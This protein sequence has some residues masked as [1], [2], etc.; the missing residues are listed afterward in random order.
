[1]DI[2]DKTSLKVTVAHWLT[3]KGKSISGNGIEPDV[4]VARTAEDVA[5]DKDPQMEKAATLLIGI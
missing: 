3:P 5:A 1:M 2:T 4:S